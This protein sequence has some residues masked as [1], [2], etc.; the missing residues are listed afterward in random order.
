MMNFNKTYKSILE[1]NSNNL[2]P[3]LVR[4]E[5]YS[6]VL[7]TDRATILTIIKP[8]KSYNVSDHNFFYNTA[9]KDSK[10]GVR[11]G[12]PLYNEVTSKW[13]RLPAVSGFYLKNRDGQF[14]LN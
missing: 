9:L 13:E 6:R 4:P 12:T 5:E 7:V 2:I 8:N 14:K 3:R 10:A 1:S 11:P